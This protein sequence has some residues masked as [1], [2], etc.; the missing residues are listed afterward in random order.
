MGLAK[1]ESKVSQKFT[2]TDKLEET[3]DDK[4]ESSKVTDSEEKQSKTLIEIQLEA[5]DRSEVN[6][7][8]QNL[9]GPEQMNI[10]DQY[11]NKSSLQSKPNKAASLE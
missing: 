9:M 3:E 11:I 1:S 8:D 10:L 2:A 5:S 7:E 6:I 4:P